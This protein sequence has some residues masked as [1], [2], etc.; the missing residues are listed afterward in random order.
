MKPRNEKPCSC[1]LIVS[2]WE[3]HCLECNICNESFEITM[4]D[5]S[6][7]RWKIMKTLFFKFYTE[8][9]NLLPREFFS[10]LKEEILLHLSIDTR[11]LLSI[12]LLKS[13]RKTCNFASRNWFL[14]QEEEHIFLANFLGMIERFTEILL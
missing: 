4:I 12:I 3:Y 7:I 13:I 10:L 5:G 11:V 9:I 14:L 1:K 2:L 6:R 8:K